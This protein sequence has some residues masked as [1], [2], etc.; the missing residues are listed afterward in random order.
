MLTQTLAKDNTKKIRIIFGAF[1]ASLIVPFSLYFPDS[2]IT[3]VTGKIL[4]S[5]GIILSSFRLTS[6]Y[7]TVKLLAL[8]YFTSFCIGGGLVAIHFLFKNQLAISK[9]G[10]LTISSGYGDP[11]SWAFIVIFFPLIWIFTKK[12]MD[13]HAIEKIRYEQLCRVTL[14]LKEVSYSTTGFIDSGNQLVDPVS[15]KPVVI[16]DESFLKQWFA[17]AEWSMMKDAYE[18]L[19]FSKIPQKWEKLIHIIPFQGVEGKSSFLIALRPE[20]L[21]VFYENKTIITHKVLIG[22][23]FAQLTK[24]GQYHCLLQPQII[25]LGRLESA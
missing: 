3:T 15:K 2:F 18:N 22:I 6:L 4:Y 25:K 16:C 13:E 24:D 20:K 9:S 10:I 5:V 19:D 14:V 17:E 12:R 1:I 21:T 7:H 11:I 23:Q 8:F